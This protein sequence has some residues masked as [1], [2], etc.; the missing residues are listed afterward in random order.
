MA[1]V[2]LLMW[3][4]FGGVEEVDEALPAELLLELSADT[5]TMQRPNNKMNASFILRC[6][7]LRAIIA[8]FF[9]YSRKTNGQYCAIRNIHGLK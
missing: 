1:L 9:I 5:L 2:L 4:A 8:V 7:V 3:V 6:G